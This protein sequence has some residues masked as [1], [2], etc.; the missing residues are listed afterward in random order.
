MYIT[1]GSKIKGFGD[2]EE[3]QKL[4]N[5]AGYTGNTS[6]RRVG[7][8][9]YARFPTFRLVLTDQRTNGR[10]DGQ[11]DGPTDKASYRVAFPQLKKEIYK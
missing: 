6:C 11:T 5:K 10:T 2:G 1:G 9:G 4:E 8:G 7:R 3:N